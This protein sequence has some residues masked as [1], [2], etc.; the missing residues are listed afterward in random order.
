MKYSIIYEVEGYRKEL[1]VPENEDCTLE[2]LKTEDRTSVT[3]VPKREMVLISAS[4]FE[5]YAYDPDSTIFVN[6]YQSWT[7]TKEFAFSDELRNIE[8]LPKA[9][10][11]KYHFHRYGDAWFTSG[12][13]VKTRA[14]Y[15]DGQYVEHVFRYWRPN[16]L[17]GRYASSDELYMYS[18][19]SVST[20][21]KEATVVW[22][23]RTAENIFQRLQSCKVP[24]I[25]D[26]TELRVYAAGNDITPYIGDHSWKNNIK[27]L[28]TTMSFKTAKTDARYISNLI[29]VPQKADI[30]QMTTDKEIFRGIVISVDDGS[31]E[32][33]GYSVVDLGWYLNKSKQTYQFKGITVTDAIKE[34]CR[35]LSI[36]I[37]TI[38]ELSV[39]VNK[40][41]FDKN[42]SEILTDLL[43]LCT[44][45]YNYDFTPEGLRIYIIGDLIAEPVFR[46]APNIAEG[47]S[48]DYMGG[49][50]HS[51][52]IENL[53]NSVKVVSEKDNVYTELLVLQDRDSIDKNGF[54][55]EIV[56]IDTEKEN[57]ETTARQYLASNNRETEKYS[58]E[59]LESI[60][61]YTR[62][63]EVMDIAG[64]R[65]VI[66]S[67]DHSIKDNF[68][69]VKIEVTKVG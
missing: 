16:N 63:G 41:Y 34:L 9:L 65:Y 61:G 17:T 37:V 57:A 64:A 23:N 58:F 31:D 3:I 2:I 50:S 7:D 38:P 49:M 32:Y 13:A 6:G 36:N 35:D 43:S 67:T 4:L 62:A 29:Y 11:K 44:G 18:A 22:N 12:R 52:S 54:L 40:I 56:K 51:T 26:T 21:E 19:N 55:Q 59:V 33:N 60:T 10:L 42:I 24:I 46:I 27:S 5:S 39:I 48:V 25:S 14:G 15:G 53:K 28:A 66:D 20:E 69:Y 1:T 47:V 8:L 68:H 45:E 30:I